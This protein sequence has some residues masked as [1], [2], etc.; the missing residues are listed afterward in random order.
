MTQ[1]LRQL[2]PLDAIK[3]FVAVGR[4]MSITAAADDL[5][6]TQSAVSRQIQSLE[7][8]FRTP[9]LIRKHRAIELTDA[10]RQLYELAAPWF[11]ELAEFTRIVRQERR[12]QPVTVTASIGV[13][14]LWIL[15]RL[16]GFQA[17]QPNVDV[18]LAASD[19]VL[20]MQQEGIDLAIRYCSAASAPPDA[21]KLFDEE[22]VL[23]AAPA[24]AEKAFAGP[25]ALLDQVLLEFDDR[26][27][28]WLRW[29]DWLRAM[30]L[31]NRQPKSTL[32]FNHYDQV[33]R[34]ALDGSGV[35]LGRTA[36]IAPMLA[37]GRL[38]AGPGKGLQAS[39]Y[40]YWLVQAT[41]QPRPEV[42]L[43]RDWLLEQARQGGLHDEAA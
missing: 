39:G 6:L 18:R 16:G 36:L 32:H 11:E 17:Q 1:Q 25:E 27:R 7:E 8:Y 5:C 29:S 33:I 30:G 2:P 28:P 31:G 10:G 23:V 34:A 37:D 26:T 20:D 35:A 9:L 13:A 24:L 3:G 22:V 21:V 4:R 38:V 12:L 41:Q 15:P 14:S 19:K 42:A 43:F 40:G